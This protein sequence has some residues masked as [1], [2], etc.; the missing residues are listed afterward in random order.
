MKQFEQYIFASTFKVTFSIE[1][2]FIKVVYGHE[3]GI[4][5]G[6]ANT[7]MKILNF[8]ASLSTQCKTVKF[9]SK[10]PQDL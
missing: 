5:N 9:L 2:K 4:R 3:G 7:K 8:L 6:E 1:S 10:F